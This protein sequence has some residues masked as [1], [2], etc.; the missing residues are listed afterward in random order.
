MDT[1]HESS[2]QLAATKILGAWNWNVEA[3]MIV[4]CTT[5][6]PLFSITDE[7]VSEGI[8][9]YHFLS[10][11]HA[12]DIRRIR[13]SI[14]HAIGSKLPFEEV[15]RVVEAGVGTRWVRSKGRC[16]YDAEGAPLHMTGFTVEAVP[17]LSTLHAS[18]VDR[19]MEART[20]AVAANERMLIKL[21]DA[22]ALEAGLQL[23]AAMKGLKD[24]R[25]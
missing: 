8:S 9:L 7:Q 22:V 6:A 15:Y 13:F 5:L 24:G 1:P 12:D 21:I 2:I 20:L 4:M 3:D 11:I 25:S 16:Y 23:A 18:I 19:L 10:L 14:G 17:G